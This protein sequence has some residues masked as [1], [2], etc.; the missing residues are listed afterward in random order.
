M[1]SH[2][3]F[4]LATAAAAPVLALANTVSITDAAAVWFEA[5]IVQSETK[6]DLPVLLA[7]NA[8]VGIITFSIAGY[9]TQGAALVSA[10]L[11][12][13][14]GRDFVDGYTEILLVVSGLIWSLVIVLYSVNLRSWLRRGERRQRDANPNDAA[15]SPSPR[16]SRPTSL[17]SVLPM[18]SLWT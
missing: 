18:N 17:W 7:R 6:A 14:W 15:L 3:S 9:V 12:L 5:K 1:A 16:I 10:L 11:S 8:Y 2:D 4:W 13:L